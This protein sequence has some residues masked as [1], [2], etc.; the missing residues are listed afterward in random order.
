MRKTHFLAD[1]AC[2]EG[3]GLWRGGRMQESS[4]SRMGEQAPIYIYPVSCFHDSHISHVSEVLK[5]IEEEIICEEMMENPRRG[6]SNQR[7]M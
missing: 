7:T 1:V 3:S 4:P 5:F 6:E 2:L